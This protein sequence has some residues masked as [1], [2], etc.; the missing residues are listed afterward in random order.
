[1]ENLT[2]DFE[3]RFPNSANVIKSVKEL[4]K[5]DLE[6]ISDT[7]LAKIID[8]RFPL[9]PIN[10]AKIPVGTIL[11]R[12]RVNK[13][14]QPYDK[15]SQIGVPPSN[16]IKE[17]GRANKPFE[18]V[19][20]C[21]SNY[22][23]AAFELLQAYKH[24][25]NAKYQVVF[26]TIGVWE[27]TQELHVASIIH[28]EVLH[29]LRDDI[30]LS[31]KQHKKIFDNGSLKEDTVQASELISQFF[32]NQFTKMVIRGTY[33]YR[34]S[35]FYSKRIQEV[36]DLIYDTYSTSKFDGINYPSVSMK[37]IADN[38][39]IFNDS[40]KNKMK[41]ID[42]LEIVASNLDFKNP[43]FLPGILHNTIAI[44]GDDIEWNP[45]I[46]NPSMAKIK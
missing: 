21:A 7:D 11:F 32:S 24:H 16:L 13:N 14:E 40:F 31:L 43:D 35:A 25:F 23:L 12:A 9:I 3:N 37:Y 17:F 45:E 38:Q 36:N 44:N 18:Q 42:A 5:L 33:D 2:A 19:F 28:S 8:D 4:E 29:E 10:T 30:V 39:A 34:I 46:Y 1:M 27:V 20:Y 15:V 41:I 22:K 26:M 6:N